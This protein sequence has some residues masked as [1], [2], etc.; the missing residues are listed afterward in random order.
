M[1]KKGYDYFKNNTE[2]EK[3]TGDFAPSSRPLPASIEKGLFKEGVEIKNVSLPRK[4]HAK[5]ISPFL[6]E[7]SKKLNIQPAKTEM[8]LKDLRGKLD[9]NSSTNLD[10]RTF[11]L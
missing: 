8:D 9:T 5:T 6:R 11:G 3:I 1:A 4:N 7:M 10:Y 2:E